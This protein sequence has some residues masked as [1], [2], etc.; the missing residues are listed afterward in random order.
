[1][2]LF[3]SLEAV[4]NLD[5]QKEKALEEIRIR[6][7]KPIVI[8]CR[9]KTR[10]TQTVPS[11]KEINEFFGYLCQDSVYAYEEERKRGYM[12]MKGGHRVGFT[13][14]VVALGKSEYFTKYICYLN[15]RI[16]HEWKNI[17]KNVLPFLMCG[18][19]P[20]NTLIVSPPGI[21][22]TTLLRDLIRTYANRFNVGVVDERGEIAGAFQGA[23]T[24][25]C[26]MFSDVITGADK[27][28]GIQ[29]LVRT[30]A[31]KLIA[32]DEIGSQDDAKAVMHAAVCG[33]KILATAHG[34]EWRDLQANE[35]I[36]QLISRKSFECF[37]FLHRSTDGKVVAEI[38]NQNGE[39]KCSGV[40]LQDVS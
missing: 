33:C 8:C 14:E 22:K 29:V 4:W 3:K 6:V 12:T 2:E 24:L 30:F 20:L 19:V 18:E 32:L 25:D 38:W 15:I 28:K 10:M 31:P 40:L 13:G 35:E 11:K 36:G 21:G 39:K 37:L 27:R 9:G 1:M 5:L 34:H 23:E 16:A 7:E 17:S 26:G